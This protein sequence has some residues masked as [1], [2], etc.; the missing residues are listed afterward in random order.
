VAGVSPD[1]LLGGG[2]KWYHFGSPTE[3]NTVEA[4][5]PTEGFT[6]CFELGGGA[7]VS[8]LGLNFDLQLLDA[9]SHYW[10]KTQHD[11][12]LSGGWVWQVR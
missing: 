10:G 9:V 6:G 7:G 2:G 11:L 12:V 1:G 8:V 3:E 5:L 4:I